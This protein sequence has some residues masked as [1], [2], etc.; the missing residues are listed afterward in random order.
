MLEWKEKWGRV[1]DE[2]TEDR[3]QRSGKEE[4]L[5]EG[6]EKWGKVEDEKAEERSEKW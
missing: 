5:M 1:E 3:D 2:K 6:K 4:S